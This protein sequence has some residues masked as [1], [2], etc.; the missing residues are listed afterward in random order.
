MVGAPDPN[1][2]KGEAFLY[3]S[4]GHLLQT[5]HDPDGQ[6]GELFGISVALSGNFVLLGADSQVNEHSSGPWFPGAAFLYTTSG[7]LVEEIREPI[8]GENGGGLFG[9]A[10][11]LGGSNVMVAGNGVSGGFPGV[12]YLYN[13]PSA[14]TTVP[15]VS[16]NPVTIAYGTALANSQLNETATATVNGQTVAIAGTFTYTYT[17]ADGAVLGAGNGQDEAV[18]FTPSDSVEYA[19]A[20]TTVVVNVAQ[21]TPHVSVKSAQIVN[22]SEV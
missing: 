21:A 16:V 7:Q 10:V 18:M 19:T 12:V 5:F 6:Y 3:D 9:H 2:Y 22:K 14:P 20:T 15:V 13:T 8:A 4:T 1:F 17:S 11:A